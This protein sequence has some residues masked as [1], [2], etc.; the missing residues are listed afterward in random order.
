MDKNLS[1]T[2]TLVKAVGVIVMVVFHTL[3]DLYIRSVVY[4]F[5]MPLF[6][7]MSGYCFKDSYLD[8]TWQYMEVC[9]TQAQRLVSAICALLFGVWVTL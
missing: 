4:T 2:V 3:P 9:F 5:H 1:N 7:L 8:N 6:F